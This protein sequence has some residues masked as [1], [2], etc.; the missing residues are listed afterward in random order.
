MRVGGKAFIQYALAESVLRI[1]GSIPRNL[2][3][4][5]GDIVAG[6]SYRLARRQR[7]TGMYNLRMALPDLSDDERAR[8]IRQ[9]FRNLGRL[10][11]E[12]SHFPKLNRDNIP[13]IV[14][15]EGFDNYL[16]GHRRGR[17]ILYLTAHVG[18]WE[19]CSFAHS[20]Y[21]YPLK[22]LTRPI[23]NP[24]IDRLITR[25]RTWGGNQVIDRT[26]AVRGV[27]KALG[28]NEAVGILADQNTTRSEGV[29]V[30]FFGIPAA[31]TPGVATFALRTGAAVIPVYLRWDKSRKRHILHFA[32]PLD[33]IV[34]GDRKQD[35]V[36]NTRMF[37]QVLETFVRKFPDQWLW[38][39]RRWKTRP[40]GEAPLY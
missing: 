39:H 9:V 30:D 17:G 27:L 28:N 37:N 21:G 5:V 11:V 32:P 3:Y 6:A 34:T 10:L 38:I 4:S 7:E 22:F 25:F 14:E 2:A 33:L 19:L 29:F 26:H 18:S 1:L 35:I 31:T 23:D 40:E 16:E 24:L 13:E 36:E 15:Y 8:I 12:F 20:I